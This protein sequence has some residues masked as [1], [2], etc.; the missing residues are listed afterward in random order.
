M[1]K[2]WA[3]Q[4]FTGGAYTAGMPLGAWT[5]FGTAWSA[6]V[7]RIFWAG[8][9]VST[10]WPGYYDGAINSAHAAV[11]AVKEAVPEPSGVCSGALSQQGL[12]ELELSEDMLAHA[13]SM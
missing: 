9:E 2:N 8:T 10:R 7:G 4:P 5:S 12:V 1:M 3:E 11:E 13:S 6:P